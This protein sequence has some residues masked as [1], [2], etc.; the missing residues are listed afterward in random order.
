M[1]L[2]HSAFRDDQLIQRFPLFY[3]RLQH[4]KCGVYTVRRTPGHSYLFIYLIDI[5]RGMRGWARGAKGQHPVSCSHRRRWPGLAFHLSAR[6]AINLQ[7]VGPT[8]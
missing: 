2:A 6:V 4:L 8:C 1:K 3:L 5:R 7:Q